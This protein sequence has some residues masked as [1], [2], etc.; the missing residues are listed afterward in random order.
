ML[1][2]F[3][4]ALSGIDRRTAGPASAPAIPTAT[5]TSMPASVSTSLIAIRGRGHIIRLRVGVEH[6]PG[7]AAP[8]VLAMARFPLDRPGLL[9]DSDRARETALD[10]P[11]SPKLDGHQVVPRVHMEPQSEWTL[12]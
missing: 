5:A 11:I 12:H 8:R 2:F 4:A 3:V 10:E 1:T 6:S 9:A 7:G